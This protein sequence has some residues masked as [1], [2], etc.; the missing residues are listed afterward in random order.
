M[1]DID[2]Q[3]LDWKQAVRV[4]E[5]IRTLR[6]DD[7][8]VRRNLVDLSLRMGQQ[9]QA[10]AEMEGFISYLQSNGQNEKIVNFLVDLVQDHEDQPVLQRTLATELQRAGRTEDAISLLDALGES[11]LNAGK[12]SEAAEVVQQII[13]MNPRGVENYRR[14]LDQLRSGGV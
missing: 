10:V 3:R 4:F 6:P 14:L 13:R 5:Q 1:A 7:E 11:L 2:M 12:K 8:G 9:E